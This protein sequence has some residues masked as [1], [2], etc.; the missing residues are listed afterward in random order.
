MPKIEAKWQ[1]F[2]LGSA[3]GCMD[4]LQKGTAWGLL[5]MSLCCCNKHAVCFGSAATVVRAE[6]RQVSV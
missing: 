4:R 3:L 1:Q 6:I 2:E 5:P